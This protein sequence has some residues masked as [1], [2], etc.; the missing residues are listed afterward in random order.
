M[1]EQNETKRTPKATVT[2]EEF[3]LTF[4]FANG[5]TKTINAKD[6]EQAIQDRAMVH[7]LEQKIRDSYAGAKSA[8][9]ALG[10]ASKV[11]DTLISGEW[12]AKREGGVSEGSIEQLARAMVMAWAEKGKEV[13]FDDTLAYVQGQTKE[14]RA[15]LRARPAVAVAL[16]K[17]R[18]AGKDVAESTGDDMIDGL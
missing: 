10:M 4:T 15:A 11:I 9:E 2:V 7:G 12:S 8:D 16:A 18:T 14:Q 1:S 17:V 6:L 5:E 13:S 3:T